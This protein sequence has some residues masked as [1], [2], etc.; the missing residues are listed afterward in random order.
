MRRELD[1]YLY[2]SMDIM[3]AL[4]AH[5]THFPSHKYINDASSKQKQL[6]SPGYTKYLMSRMEFEKP[7]VLTVIFH[8]NRFQLRSIIPP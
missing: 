1:I 6:Y 5:H 3:H 2:I 8:A 4:S 7:F